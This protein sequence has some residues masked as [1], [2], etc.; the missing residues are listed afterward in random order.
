M[1]GNALI[2]KKP[3]NRNPQIHRNALLSFDDGLFELAVAKID[4]LNDTT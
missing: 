2:N 1:P 4:K 3:P